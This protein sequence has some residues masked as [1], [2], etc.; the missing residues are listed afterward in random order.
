[1]DQRVFTLVGDENHDYLMDYYVACDWMN[2]P[3]FYRAVD[4][5]GTIIDTPRYIDSLEY[6]YWN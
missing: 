1:M 4:T 2:H 3:N 6:M 5:R